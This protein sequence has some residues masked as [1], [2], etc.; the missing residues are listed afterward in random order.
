MML[1]HTTVFVVTLLPLR[2][3]AEA[4]VALLPQWTLPV[5]VVGVWRVISRPKVGA[6][7]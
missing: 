3:K 2:L 4:P 6:R 1:N 5:R 7:L